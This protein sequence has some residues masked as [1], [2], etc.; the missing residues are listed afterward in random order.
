MQMSHKPTRMNKIF[1]Q[2]KF[3]WSEMLLSCRVVNLNNLLT[4]DSY[5]KDA[6]CATRIK[7]NKFKTF[8][9]PRASAVPGVSPGRG[10]LIVH[11]R[12]S[13]SMF[14]GDGDQIFLVC[15]NVMLTLVSTIW[16]T[17]MNG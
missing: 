16:R 17:M 1:K 5:F 8:S 7:H 12:S 6:R 14:M 3:P 9:G 15:H 13:K 2:T 10:L 11:K 4:L